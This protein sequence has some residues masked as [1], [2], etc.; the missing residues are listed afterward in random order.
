MRACNDALQPPT[1][2]R[3]SRL[4][5]RVGT[6]A[7]SSTIASSLL[8]VSEDVLVPDAVEPPL[9]KFKSLFEESDPDKVA[10][11]SLEEYSSQHV[12]SGGES[13]TQ[14][15]PS[16]TFAPTTQT[17][18][19]SLKDGA[20]PI[21][22]GAVPEEEEES[23]LHTGARMEEQS[24]ARGT[25][26][27]SQAV[28]EEGDVEI[29]DGEPPR[30]RR[31]T[32]EETTDGAAT[33]APAKPLSKQVTRVDMAHSQVYVKPK[34]ASKKAA[35]QKAGEPDKDAA[36]LKAVASTKRGKKAED[37]FDREFNNLRISKPDLEREREDEVWKVLEEFGDDGD[38]RGNF[39]VVEE[40]SLF[41]EPGSNAHLR[42]G[43]GRLEWQGRPDFKKF[44]RVRLRSIDGVSAPTNVLV[45]R[46]RSRIGVSR[47]SLS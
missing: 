30:T 15:E 39:M 35:T 37:T 8:P 12:P 26:R 21:S 7:P 46:K 16:V 20:T 28:D 32:G 13:I 19:H 38:V 3:P 27:K 24:Q 44:K 11:M 42:R 22:L 2:S 31:R 9:K 47:S 17:R 23:T 14:Y 4:K 41:R 1:P 34:P 45:F 10:K 40:I 29:K 18:S 6:R 25:K 5:R 43:E 36:F 33:N